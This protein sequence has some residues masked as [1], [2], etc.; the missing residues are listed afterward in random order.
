MTD[1]VET[2]AYEKAEVPWHGLGV[3]VENNLS[4]AQML[5]AAK[6]NW[7]VSKRP[8]FYQPNGE[9]RILPLKEKFVLMRE[10]DETPLSV[11]GTSYKPVQNEDAMD[12]FKRFI[13]AG[14]MKMETAGSLWG[15]RYIWGLARIGKDFKVG[16][17]D[18][19]NNY[20]LLCSPH[21]HGKALI[22]QTTSIR[23]VCWNTLSWALGDKLKGNKSAWHMP[24]STTFDDKTKDAA[25]VALGL[26]GQ[27]A[28]EF[29]EAAVLLSKKKVDDVAAE[30][31]FQEVLFYDPKKANTKKD[32]DPR[33]PRML[34]KFREA[35]ELAPGAMLPGSK[36][37]LWGAL[38]AVTFTI[39]HNTGRE[40]GTALKNAWLGHTANIKRRALQLALDRAK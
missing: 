29:K 37:T 38:N 2:M 20:L 10:S 22:M 30:K 21:V 24:H 23:V 35:L 6:L 36:G 3:P 11:V 31:Y 18:Q 33:E 40:R 16:K 15:G 19:V 26:A 25:A 12:F 14:K 34:P 28:D 39:D 1:A 7:K 5:K 9:D 27:Q 4:A 17:D 13:D 32:G 8:M